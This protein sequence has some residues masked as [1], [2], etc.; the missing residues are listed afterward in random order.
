MGGWREQEMPS[1]S[2][3]YGHLTSCIILGIFCLQC[4]LPASR[5]GSHAHRHARRIIVVLEGVEEVPP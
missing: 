2:S 4:W 3:W 1:P 5:R